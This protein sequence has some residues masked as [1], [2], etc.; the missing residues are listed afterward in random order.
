[1]NNEQGMKNEGEGGWT[2]HIEQGMKNDDG[3]REQGEENELLSAQFSTL[4]D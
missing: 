2:M 4:D 3:N 1:M